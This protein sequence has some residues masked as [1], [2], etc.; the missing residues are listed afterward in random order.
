MPLKQIEVKSKV[1]KRYFDPNGT[2]SLYFSLAEK[3]SQKD[4]RDF[5]L[6]PCA[7]RLTN[8]SA[9]KGS[10]GVLDILKVHLK[11]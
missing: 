2:L 6:I 5:F 4:D 9:P 11:T 8:N 10:K 7:L 1:H 3:D